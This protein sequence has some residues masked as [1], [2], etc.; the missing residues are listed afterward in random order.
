MRAASFLNNVTEAAAVGALLLSGAALYLATKA[1]E[2]AAPVLIYDRTAVAEQIEPYVRAGLDPME[3]IEQAIGE[4]TGRGYFVVDSDANIKGPTGSE[5]R[6]DR[7]VRVPEA[8]A[9]EAVSKL[10]AQSTLNAP[11]GAL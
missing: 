11:E 4:A 7:F 2:T 1:P 10:D 6:L 9:P 5:F 3:I 8:E